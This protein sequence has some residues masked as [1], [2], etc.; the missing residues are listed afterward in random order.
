M[1]A[2][3]T[4]D[5]R[6]HMM[7]HVNSVPVLHAAEPLLP[8]LPLPLPLLPSFEFSNSSSPF[9]FP[10]PFRFP[11]S[12]KF[13]NSDSGP[14]L[15]CQPRR[16]FLRSKPSLAEVVCRFGQ[17]IVHLVRKKEAGDFVLPC[18]A[19]VCRETRRKG[20]VQLGVEEKGRRHRQNNQHNN[21]N[22]G[23]RHIRVDSETLQDPLPEEGKPGCCAKKMAD[24]WLHDGPRWIWGI[25]KEIK[26][27]G[28][29]EG[30]SRR[31]E[32]GGGG[33]LTPVAQRA[34]LQAQKKTGRI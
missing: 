21:L 31:G 27:G 6:S 7:D 1:K 12:S 13:S 11:S 29:K 15:F 25:K 3:E 5:S 19:N 4:A 23:G 28:R 18:Q 26:K 20:A 24:L 30:K 8:L 17:H 9:G 14:R 2:D 10:S 34:K 33:S 16:L 32:E 22:H